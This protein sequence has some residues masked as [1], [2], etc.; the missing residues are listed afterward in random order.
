MV[1]RGRMAKLR[2]GNLEIGDE[3][4]VGLEGVRRVVENVLEENLV[5]GQFM[6]DLASCPLVEFLR[7]ELTAACV[8][9]E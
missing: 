9:L 1:V 3:V 8:C 6:N 5:F 7:Q 2:T 4:L